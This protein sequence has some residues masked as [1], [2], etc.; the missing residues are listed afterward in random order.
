MGNVRPES[1]EK[2]SFPVPLG[3]LRPIEVHRFKPDEVLSLGRSQKID[4]GTLDL[5]LGL[6][7]R[8]RHGIDGSRSPAGHCN[9]HTQE[10]CACTTP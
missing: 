5:L 3:E 2:G 8:L 10:R 1:S 6:R 4:E 7:K 9:D